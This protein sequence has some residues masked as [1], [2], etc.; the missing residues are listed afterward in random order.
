M[1]NNVTADR[2]EGWTHKVR[3]GHH[4]FNVIMPKHCE[5]GH[6][7]PYR[8]GGGY[9]C[10]HVFHGVCSFESLFH[11]TDAFAHLDD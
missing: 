7:S 10:K 2:I 1:S 6:D 8:V 11:F 4:F 5:T 9:Y 3:S